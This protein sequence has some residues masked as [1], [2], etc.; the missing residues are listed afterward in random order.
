MG[1]EFKEFLIKIGIIYAVLFNNI[2]EHPLALIYPTISD[3]PTR[4]LRELRQCYSSD[5][6][7]KHEE[8]L[9]NAI[10]VIRYP[11][12]KKDWPVAIRE[13]SL[14]I[15]TLE[16]TLH[17]IGQRSGLIKWS[18]N[19][20]P[21]LKLP[22]IENITQHQRK[23]SLF[24]PDPK[25]G[26]LY[27]YNGFSAADTDS[28]SERE[29][30]EKLPFTISELVSSSPC[31]SSDGL[32]YTGKKI[33]EWITINA[34]TGERV[35]VLNADTP[36]C[37]SPP[38]TTTAYGTQTSNLLFIGKSEYQ[39]S[40]FDL[41]SK[42]KTWNLTFV[43]YSSSAVSSIP[44]NAY[45]FLHLTSST[46]GRIATIDL[47]NDA[48]RF[49]WTHQFSS[50]IVS[51]F[52][53][54]D[55][56][57]P[58][59]RRVPFSTIG[60]TVIP[61][62]LRQ[63]NPLYPSLYIGEMP[64]S[65][66][67]YALSTL[68]DLS[69]T[70]LI[71]TKRNRKLLI[72]G[73]DKHKSINSI[74]DYF[75]ILVFGY[76]EYP[77]VTKSQIYP[78]FQI[79]Q[80]PHNLLTAH[81]AKHVTEPLIIGNT[82]FNTR[83]VD[84]I[85]NYEELLRTAITFLL[86]VTTIALSVY[87]VSR[88]SKTDKNQKQNQNSDPNWVSV[89]KI[90]FEPKS[91]IGRG[92]S[93]TCVYK[94]LFEGKQKIAVKRVVADHF[95]LADREIE[96]LRSL[97]HP[98]LIRYFATESD[99]MF[100]YIAIELAD[101]TLADYLEREGGEAL[102]DPIQVL[103]Q[104]ALGL[105]HLHSLN[106]IHRD[107]K[108][109][110]ILIS[111]PLPPN[112]T[113]KVMISDF[114]VSKVLT[115]EHMSTEVS[116]A[117]KGTEGWIAAEV[118]KSKVERA[119]FKPSKPIDIFSM[120]CLFYY[121][122]TK[123]EHPFGDLLQRQSNI[124]M[125]RFDIDKLKTEE[126]FAEYSLIY[127]MINSDPS[128]RPNI[129][130]VAKHPLFWDPNKSLQFLQDVS[131]RIEKEAVDSD[132]VL[133]LERGGIDVCKGD[134]RRHISIELQADL[135]KFRSYRGSSVRDLLRAMRN[136]RHHYRELTPE[137]QQSLGAIPKQFVEYWDSRYP[138]LLIHSYIALQM[139]RNE[140]I[141][142]AYYRTDSVYY[143]SLPRSGIKWFTKNSENLMPNGLTSDDSLEAINWKSCKRKGSPVKRRPITPKPDDQNS[144][145][146]FVQNYDK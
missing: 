1:F 31:R 57:T 98:N 101:F 85:Y 54:N 49:L 104:S 21:I 114:G 107:I 97:Q 133:N 86:G 37:P 126:T 51:I 83:D 129:E 9:D 32:L 84:V 23:K 56:I 17:A 81:K 95:V 62:N 24:L 109:Q 87:I 90:R 35:D 26:S 127:T 16:G 27:L 39:L 74:K 5:Q 11:N 96:L 36:M 132:V 45:E 46:T 14:L 52:Q 91:I 93:G 10:P 68:V 13:P 47:S 79:S 140:D 40:I 53:F 89:G 136:K 75:N 113:R 120:G 12:M 69:Q 28:E 112:N 141:F 41:K 105:A 111:L 67:M 30:L 59:L 125:G 80:S 110:N 117:L 55:G 66:S 131:D 71:P 44:Q 102:V 3:E 43:D 77:E 138:R 60:G 7:S 116:A 143:E 73:P 48:N 88:N 70:T 4:G 94:G 42:Q 99:D 119:T 65:K 118:L 92:C 142:D 139:C 130:A 78:Q 106:V 2:L 122:L 146:I 29:S 108:P 50:P 19:E 128:A 20:S 145:D 123:G 25:D 38:M 22:N 72:E 76:Y 61:R 124:L 33:D 64:D 137:V 103:H 115:S 63:S 58:V 82:S 34:V 134:W 8:G 100:R 18:L 6:V 15:S 121:T 144:A 135:K